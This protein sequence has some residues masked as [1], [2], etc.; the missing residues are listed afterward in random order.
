[1]DLTEQF[2]ISTLNVPIAPTPTKQ[3]KAMCT[4][5]LNCPKTG[6]LEKADYFE[7]IK[8]LKPTYL[9]YSKPPNTY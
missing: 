2:I 4:Y 7:G 6:L 3:T 5:Y 1:V 8:V 9:G